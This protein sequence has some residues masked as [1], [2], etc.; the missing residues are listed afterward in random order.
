MVTIKTYGY[1]SRYMEDKDSGTFSFPD[2]TT[3]LEMLKVLNIP[4][5]G[6]GFVSVNGKMVDK[7]Y[8]IA[9]GDEI[10]IFPVV[11]GG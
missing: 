6:V 4:D 10:K 11:M 1:L 5:S 7:N 9:Q 3:V 2:G 8:Q